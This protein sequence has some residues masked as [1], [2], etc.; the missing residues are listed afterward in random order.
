M[1]LKRDPWAASQ[2]S[3]QFP[4][5]RVCSG[6]FIRWFTSNDNVPR[7]HRNSGLP[8]MREAWSRRWW[9]INARKR[10]DFF[11]FHRFGSSSDQLTMG[12]TRKNHVLFLSLYPCCKYQPFSLTTRG[13]KSIIYNMCHVINGGVGDSDTTLV[14]TITEL[15]LLVI[16]WAILFCLQWPGVQNKLQTTGCVHVFRESF[17]KCRLMWLRLYLKAWAYIANL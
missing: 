13:G 14:W 8:F 17:F 4:L 2:I 7:R 3:L 11:F 9:I 5:N 10:N 6:F 12:F 16:C 15:F 1:G